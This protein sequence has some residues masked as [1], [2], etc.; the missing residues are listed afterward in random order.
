[1][2]DRHDDEFND[3]GQTMDL[4]KMRKAGDDPQASGRG[5]GNG[6]NFQKKAESFLEEMRRSIDRAIKSDFTRVEALP[7]ERDVLERATAPVRDV[8]TQNYAAWRRSVLWL[9]AALLVIHCVALLVNYR[10]SEEIMRESF[11]PFVKQ[12]MEAQTF[13]EPTEQQIDLGL[14]AAIQAMGS[15]NIE[16]LDAIKWVLIL[17]TL[18]GAALVFRAARQWFDVAVSRDWTRY[19][20]LVMFLAPIVLCLIPMSSFLDFSHI[21]SQDFNQGLAQAA[22]DQQ[23]EQFEQMFRMAIATTLLLFTVPKIIALFA[24]AIRSAITVKTLVPESTTPGVAI[25]TLAPLYALFVVVASGTVI[26]LKGGTELIIGTLAVVCVPVVYLVHSNAFLKP[27][28]REE[29]EVSVVN[30]R[31]VALL[32][33]V[34]GFSL[35]GAFVAGLDAVD[36]AELFSA[37]TLVLGNVLLLSVVGADFMLYSIHRDYVQTRDVTGTGLIESLE[38]KL[39][40]FDELGLTRLRRTDTAAKP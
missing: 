25:V 5:G 9:S 8:L 37:V 19:G 33:N 7:S 31:R 35:L 14:D 12:G 15:G 4:S 30:A 22:I 39:S 21:D 36:G 3:A 38:G 20:F 27:Q 2:T 26:Q 28:T 17:A 1:M 24:G 34:V 13:Q 40:H 6:N 16:V 11:R 32:F 29:I 23:K 10:G 18:I